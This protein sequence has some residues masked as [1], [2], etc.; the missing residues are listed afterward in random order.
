MAFDKKAYMWAYRRTKTY[1]RKNRQALKRYRE[2]P[3]NNKKM[4]KSSAAWHKQH[5]ESHRASSVKWWRKKNGWTSELFEATRASQK[6]A[7]A[8]CRKK[9]NKETPRADHKHS[10]PPQPRGLLCHRCNTAL[11]LFMDNPSICKAAARYLKKYS[12]AR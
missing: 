8:I 12:R 6:N 10:K 7:C 2:N 3:D 4:K 1:R 9:F 5:P 11:G